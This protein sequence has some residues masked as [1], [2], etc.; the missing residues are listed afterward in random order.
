MTNYV[1]LFMQRGIIP[2][3]HYTRNRPSLPFESFNLLQH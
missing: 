2:G 3:D 1:A